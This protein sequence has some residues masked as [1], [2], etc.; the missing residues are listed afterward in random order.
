MNHPSQCK[1]A[2][3]SDNTHG[4]CVILLAPAFVALAFEYVDFDFGFAGT[5]IHRE[6]DRGRIGADPYDFLVAA[7]A[8]TDKKA[9]PYA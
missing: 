6:I 7:A 5:T 4:L 2:G 9:I 8:R 3:T 1:K